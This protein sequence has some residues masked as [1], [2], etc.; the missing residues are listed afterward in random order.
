MCL[1]QHKDKKS[2][3]KVQ[4][5]NRGNEETTTTT[6]ENSKDKRLKDKKIII[7]VLSPQ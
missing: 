2:P 3:P 6:K 7:R 1:T 4:S 5:T